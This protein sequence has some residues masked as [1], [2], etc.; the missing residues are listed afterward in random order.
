MIVHAPQFWRVEKVLDQRAKECEAQGGSVWSEFGS[1]PMYTPSATCR[2]LGV[3]N[4]V[5]WA[6][7]VGQVRGLVWVQIQRPTC[8]HTN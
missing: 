6:H 3:S 5:E 8:V 7:K 1:V 2:D 4:G